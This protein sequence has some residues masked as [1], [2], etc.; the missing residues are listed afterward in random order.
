MQS[1]M[2]KPTVILSAGARNEPRSRAERSETACPAVAGQPAGSRRRAR[3]TIPFSFEGATLRLETRAESIFAVSVHGFARDPS[4]PPA[5]AGSAANDTS[6]R[7]R[8]LR[9]PPGH[10][11]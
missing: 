6:G 10:A 3:A 4:T 9:E 5:F 11:V 7:A 2:P 1:E 8:W